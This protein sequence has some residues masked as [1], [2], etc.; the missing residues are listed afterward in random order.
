MAR[1]QCNATVRNGHV[2]NG[3]W[4]Q[5]THVG[6]EKV[7]AKIRAGYSGDASTKLVESAALHA[8]ITWIAESVS[9]FTQMFSALQKSCRMGRYI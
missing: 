4:L 8:N 6:H 5:G 9:S 1:W 2:Q 3:V 7:T